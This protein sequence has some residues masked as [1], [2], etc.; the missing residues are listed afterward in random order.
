M[1]EI[2]LEQVTKRFGDKVAVHDTSL[3]IAD[4]EFLVLLGPSG[5]GKTTLLRAI[6]GL[7]MADSGRI[8]IGGRDVTYLPPG[9]RQIS[10]VFQSYAIF[11]HMTVR[12]NIGF[13][14]QM[15]KVDKAEI[16]RRV[17]SAAE[18]LHIEDLL[19][20]RPSAMSGGQRQRVAVARALAMEAKV[21]LMDEPLSNLDALLRLEMRAEL[22]RLLADVDATTVYVTHD[23]IEALSM[24]DRVAVM[25]DGEIQ[26][27]DAPNTVYESPSNR[28][29][30][31]FIGNPPMNFLDGAILRSDDDVVVAVG[32]HEFSPASGVRPLI[33]DL[34]GNRV[35]LGIRAE[36]METLTAPGP[37]TVPVRVDVVEP[38]GAQNLLTVQVAGHRLKVSTHPTLRVAADDELHIRFP[39]DQIRWIDPATDKVLH[40]R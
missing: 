32:H 17:G 21:L 11:P 38:L 7:G 40:T 33:R 26:Q 16:S 39:A 10:M 2:R 20:R 3:T 12:D 18:L 24:G 25:R 29:V 30:G 22:K 35:T 5:C 1:A 19:D 14:L 37:D 13:G 28:F 34:S 9:Q 36:N 6:A 15:N 27:C 4:R 8:T 31:S 23:Q